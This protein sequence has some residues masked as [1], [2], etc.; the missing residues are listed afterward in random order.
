MQDFTDEYDTISVGC[1]VVYC[2]MTGVF[3]S[4]DKLLPDCSTEAPAPGDCALE[5]AKAPGCDA[6]AFT[7][8]ED[9]NTSCYFV[10]DVRLGDQQY[11]STERTHDDDADWLHV[12]VVEGACSAITFVTQGV[13]TL[14]AAVPLAMSHATC[15][16]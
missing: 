3:C 13:L 8:D 10:G 16:R 1:N 7:A 5:C 2:L 14:P 15:C 4:S 6:A 11:A 12:L 9:L